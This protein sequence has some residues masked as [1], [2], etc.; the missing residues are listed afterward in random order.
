MERDFMGLNP[1]D[2]VVIKEEFVEG[3]C[4]DSGFARTSG[5]PWPFLNK[6]SAL[7]QYMSLKSEEDAKLS[8]IKSDLFASHGYIQKSGSDRFEAM[9][10]RQTGDIQNGHAAHPIQDAKMHPFSMMSPFLKTRFMGACQNFG[11]ATTKQ[12]FLGGL[13]APHSNFLAS[14]AP[15]AGAAE[16]GNNPKAS[17]A[18]TQLTIF[19]GGTVNVFDDITPEKA[20]AII[21][22][23]GNGCVPSNMAQSELHMQA[24]ASKPA[25]DRALVN[26]SLDMPSS[27]SL[28]SPMSI[29]SRPIDH[30]AAKNDDV[31]VSKTGGMSTTV[32]NEVEPRP[33]RVISPIRSVVASAMMSS[34]VPQARK[35]SLARFLEKRK[36]RATNAAPYNLSKNES[37][38][39]GFS[40]TSGV[41]SSSVSISKR[42]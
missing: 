35:A 27:S 1:K 40:A 7:P 8:K 39:F 33:P 29:S 18:P 37:N 10:K 6:M 5:V 26:Q 4:E 41:C 15:V 22:L 19:Y 21:F 2:S 30:S 34:A 13:S 24:P 31:R 42:D 23:A 25:A 11:G 9:H 12:Q 17:A 14:A 38:D 36:E 20:Q 32:V 16:Q 28:P 3:G